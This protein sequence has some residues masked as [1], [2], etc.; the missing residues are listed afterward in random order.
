MKSKSGS[1]AKPKSKGKVVKGEKRIIVGWHMK[2]DKC[3]H[4]NKS[5]A[6]EPIRDV[7]HVRRIMKMLSDNR[8]NF[9]LFVLG[10]HTNLRASDLLKLQYRDV[11]ETDKTI[12]DGFSIREKKSKKIK[13]IPLH[14]I[15]KKAL[16]GLLPTNG[17]PI[18]MD[19]LLFPSRKINQDGDRQMSVIALHGLVKQWCKQAGLKGHYGSHTMRKT[20]AYRALKTGMRID[21]LMQMLNHSSMASTLRY[22][23]T[24]KEDIE[25]ATLQVR[26]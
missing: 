15:T 22:T 9:A 16:M 4:K 21:I 23:G 11:V 10:I 2:T 26:F 20:F 5:I 6:V 3:P 7:K 18:D 12:V 25:Q 19:A 8:R 13:Y 17:S 1:K 24:T 14:S